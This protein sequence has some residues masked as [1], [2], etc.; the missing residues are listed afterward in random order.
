MKTND[1]F[2]IGY[3][4]SYLMSIK[5]LYEKR[6]SQEG[7][8]VASDF[9]KVFDSLNHNFTITD[10]EHYGF[11]NDF[12]EWIKTLLNN[13]ESLMINGSQTANY[14]RLEGGARQRDPIS[15][16]LFILALEI[17]FIFIKLS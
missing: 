16:Y 10:L 1:L 5:N 2:L 13:Q 6:Q 4:F 11:G 7:E 15:A 12:I 14:F 8:L 3:L 17:L 9:E